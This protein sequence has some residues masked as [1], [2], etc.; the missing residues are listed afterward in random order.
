MTT[1]IRFGLSLATAHPRSADPHQ[2][3]WDL[4][5]RVQLAR[6]LGFHSVWVGDHHVTPPLS[7]KP[8]D[9]R[10]HLS[11]VRLHA[12]R[13]AVHAPLFHPVLLA[14]QIVTLDVICEGRLPL[15]TA[16]GGQ[17]EVYAAFGIP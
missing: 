9:D 3:V 1:P 17:P 14:E 10:P 4:L 6:N 12:N 2:C 7:A 5:E 13:C 8:A 15:E 16:V 11:H